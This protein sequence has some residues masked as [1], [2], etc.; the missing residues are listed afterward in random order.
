VT[1]LDSSAVL[2]AIFLEPGR[3]RVVQAIEQG[4][5]MSTVNITEVI[6]RLIDRGAPSDV[7]V[8]RMRDTQVAAVA[9]DVEMA[10][11]AAELREHTRHLGLSLGDRACLALGLLRGGPVLTADRGWGDLDLGVAI[12][13]IR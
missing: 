6:T 2:A 12:E 3:A 8:R 4:V 7:A 11:L 5:V 9:F 13:V 10:R 1:V